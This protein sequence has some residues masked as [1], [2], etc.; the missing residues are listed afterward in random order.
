MSRTGQQKVQFLPVGPGPDCPLVASRG[1]TRNPA[2][3]RARARSCTSE[4]HKGLMQGQR[5]GSATLSV[6]D[7]A[8][9]NDIPRPE[10]E[11]R[12]GGRPC[13]ALPWF[14]SRIP[15]TW[16]SKN[17]N[18]FVLAVIKASGV[19][20]CCETPSKG[21]HPHKAPLSGSRMEEELSGLQPELHVDG[22][23]SKH[24]KDT[25]ETAGSPQVLRTHTS[26]R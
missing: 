5:H 16:A 14:H 19:C 20:H 15:P 9:N 21:R 2:P 11:R 6:V 26:R 13:P 25:D 12:G 18:R 3:S 4:R 1:G 7:K 10:R 22:G 23:P 8:S 17:F 24:L